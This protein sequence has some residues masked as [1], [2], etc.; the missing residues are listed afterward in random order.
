VDFTS[1]REG[2]EAK[3][4]HDEALQFRIGARRNKLLGLWAAERLGKSGAEAETFARSVVLADLE[5]PGD[6]DVI[7]KIM[8]EFKAGGC[9]E[10]EG[11]IREMLN[12][13]SLRAADDMRSK[14]AKV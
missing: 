3:F 10:T 14:L 12:S 9:S 2:F 13:F 6:E 7:R 11:D 8:E 5:E 1:R 4:A